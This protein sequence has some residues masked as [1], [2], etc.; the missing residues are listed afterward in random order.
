MRENN[1]KK[2]CP[3]LI[4]NFKKWTL[5]LYWGGIYRE[6]NYGASRGD[7]KNYKTKR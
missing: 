7:F 1:L 6:L 4:I 3:E 5:N 2:L